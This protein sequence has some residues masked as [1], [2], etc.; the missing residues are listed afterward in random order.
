M[1]PHPHPH[2]G[3][4]MGFSVWISA[5]EGPP[6][7]SLFTREAATINRKLQKVREE[8]PLVYLPPTSPSTLGKSWS[9]GKADKGRVLEAEPSLALS[10]VR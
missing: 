2:P 4:L 3:L 5:T 1:L 7:L 10:I 6:D 8:E 9:Q